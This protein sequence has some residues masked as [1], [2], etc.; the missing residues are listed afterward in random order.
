MP[1]YSAVLTQTI[2]DVVELEAENL[3]EAWDK[4]E[5]LTQTYVFSGF[6]QY[7][8]NEVTEVVKIKEDI[9]G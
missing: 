7:I 4:A 8:E 5:E 9:S 1:K 6:S 2:Y 3:G